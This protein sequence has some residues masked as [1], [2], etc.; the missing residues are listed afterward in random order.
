MYVV[1]YIA[2]YMQSCS[3]AVSLP[4]QTYMWPGRFVLAEG[5]RGMDA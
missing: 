5:A 4:T 3:H 1:L 2:F